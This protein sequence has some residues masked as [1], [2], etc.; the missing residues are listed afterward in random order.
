MAHDYI[1]TNDQVIANRNEWSEQHFVYQRMRSR[2]EQLLHADEHIALLNAAAKRV[3]GCEITLTAKELQEAT[4][5]LVRYSGR[6][7]DMPHLIE[8]RYYD[9]GDYTC[10]INESSLYKCFSLRAV[11]PI[12]EVFAS[13]SSFGTLPTSAFQAELEFSRTA[14]FGTFS[15]YCH[16]AR[17][18]FIYH[19]II[20][21]VLMLKTEYV[22]IG[23]RELAVVFN[24][25]IFIH[26]SNL[27]FV[28][29][30]SITHLHPFVNTFFE[31]FESC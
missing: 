30:I 17:G 15:L 16:I 6:R 8:V 18:D 10:R 14:L 24:H 21:V 13:E 31:S 1:Y 25:S 22:G 29:V 19:Y 12:G 3:F 9:N 2:G 27:S 7:A 20:N 11:H 28:S 26:S 5:K 23:S 4:A